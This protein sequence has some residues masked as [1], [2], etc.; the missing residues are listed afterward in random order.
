M[1]TSD[2]VKLVLQADTPS[3]GLHAA[4]LELLFATTGEQQQRPT[5]SQD[6][7]TPSDPVA[8]LKAAWA[9][10]CT[11]LN[12]ESPEAFP[13]ERLD[14]L[15]YLFRCTAYVLDYTLS[16]KLASTQKP[17]EEALARARA[18]LDKVSPSAETAAKT[19]EAAVQLPEVRVMAGASRI[20]P[21]SFKELMTA[22]HGQ[23][24]AWCQGEMAY[25]HGAL[26]AAAAASRLTDARGIIEMLLTDNQSPPTL[27]HAKRFLK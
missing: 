9:D 8:A 15:P 22:P 6:G 14:P 18:A 1:L 13:T 11:R 7:A 10:L 4:M 20:Q 25:E 26:L 27:E 23:F 2:L 17:S 3:E 24:R 16:A 21:P 19:T 5:D 12:Q